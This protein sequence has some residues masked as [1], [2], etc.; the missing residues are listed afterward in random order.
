M[1]SRE[2][3]I[4]AHSML[5]PVATRPALLAVC[6]ALAVAGCG[7]SGPSD[8]EQIR[9]ALDRFAR[10]TAERDYATLCDRVLAPE[11]VGT[12]EQIGLPCE[13]ALEKAF[14]DVREP[15]ISVGA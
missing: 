2:L 7:D 8:E 11:L 15:R 13:M 14:E 9:A 12:L 5:R 3:S 10:A 6:A 4:P 1:G